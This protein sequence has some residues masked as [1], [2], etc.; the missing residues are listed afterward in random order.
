MKRGCLKRAGKVWLGSRTNRM[1]EVIPVKHRSPYS[2]VNV[3]DVS[4]AEMVNRRRGQKLVIGVDVAKGEL[5]ACLVGPDGTFD[6]P[7][8]IKSPDQVRLLVSKL[9][10]LREDCPL[11]V[12]M[13]S[14]GHLRGS[15]ASGVV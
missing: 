11:V 4:I 13:E 9:V 2:C 6:R 14:I 15:A 12:A 8:K 1:Q 3:N 10:E 7:W 5:V